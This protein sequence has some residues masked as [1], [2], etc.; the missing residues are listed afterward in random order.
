LVVFP[1]QSEVQELF[2]LHGYMITPQVRGYIGVHKPPSK[3]F[4]MIGVGW[5]L[6]IG[7][8]RQAENSDE[9]DFRC[10]ALEVDGCLGLAFFQ[11]LRLQP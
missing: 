10:I 5:A 8:P 4:R 1:T 7:E 3:S 2:W 11:F 9:E 6:G